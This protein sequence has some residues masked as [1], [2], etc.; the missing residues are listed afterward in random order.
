MAFGRSD[1][2]LSMMVV[3]AARSDDCGEQAF[4]PTIE[5]W[6]GSNGTAG[7]LIF[8]GGSDT[9]SFGAAPE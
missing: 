6:V 3:L 5:S 9:P 1:A 4:A 8:D 7:A 2:V